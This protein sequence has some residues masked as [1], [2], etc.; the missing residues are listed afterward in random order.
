MSRGSI[1]YGPSVVW[2]MLETVHSHPA[3]LRGWNPLVARADCSPSSWPLIWV[4]AVAAMGVGST[5]ECGSC[6]CREIKGPVSIHKRSCILH[7]GDIVK[8]ASQIKKKKLVEGELLKICWTLWKI[9]M[10]KCYACKLAFIYWIVRELSS[11]WDITRF[12][13]LPLLDT[14]P[15]RLLLWL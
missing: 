1:R 4:A 14:P 9:L 5:P 12:S 2:K 15:R 7:E 8:E 11:T 3:H 10:L 13:F 6:L